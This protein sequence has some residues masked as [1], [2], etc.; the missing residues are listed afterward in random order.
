VSPPMQMTTDGREVTIAASMQHRRLSP[1]QRD[2]MRMI[3]HMGTL[4]SV[5]AGKILLAH[6]IPPRGEQYAGS[7]GSR[8]MKRLERRGLVKKV[9]RGLWEAEKWE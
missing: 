9:K 6:R 7:D 8:L 3:R 4:R 5:E 2:V 1:A